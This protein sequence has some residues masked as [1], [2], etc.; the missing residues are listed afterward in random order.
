MTPP[1][2]EADSLRYLT[3][4]LI[5]TLAGRGILCA[6]GQ[7]GLGATGWLLAPAVAQAF[8][9]VALGMS[10]VLGAPIRTVSIPVWI[11]VL[12]LATG[13]IAF[14][15]M[16][17]R[18]R[19][20]GVARFLGGPPLALG[21]AVLVPGVG[22]LPYFVHGFGAYPGTTH[23]DAWSY[24]VFSAYLWEYPRL[25]EGGLSPAYQWAANL[26]GTRF[27][28]SASLGWL[29]AATHER[30]TQGAFGLLLVLSTFIIGSTCAAVGRGLGLPNKLLPLV[31]VGSGAGNWIAN[32][33][34]VSN[35]DNLL[36]LP[37]LPALAVLGIDKAATAPEGRA[38]VAGLLAAGTLYTYPEFALVVLCCGVLY[39][40]DWPLK[41]PSRQGL[42]SIL[43]CALT[44]AVLISPYVAELARFLQYQFS[45]G[46]SPN[47]RPGE[48][49]FS[50]LLDASRMPAALWALGAE[51][52]AKPSQWLANAAGGALSLLA[53]IGFGRLVRDRALG[54]SAT[55]AIL[56][57][58]FSVFVWRFDY[59]YGAYKFI[60]LGWW[61]A[62][63][64]VVLGVRECSR[65]H[66][67]VTAVAAVVATGTF[68]VALS[69][70]VD[71]AMTPVPSSMAAF[72]ELRAV[73]QLAHGAPIAIAVADNTAAHWATYFL[74]GSKTRLVSYSGYLAN[75]YFQPSM[76]RA[77]EIPW[78]SLR[79]LLTDATDGGPFVEQQYWKRLWSNSHYTLWD[80][81]DVGWAVVGQIDNGYPYAAG[82]DVVW[83][84]D[85]PVTLVATASAAGIATVHT[86]LALSQPLSPTV[87]PFRLLVADAAGVKCEWTLAARGA[88][89]L[90]GLQPG[91]NVVTL[92]KTSPIGVKV[93]P[94]ADQRH[95]FMVGLLKPTLEFTRGATDAR[96][97]H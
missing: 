68:S 83:V 16:N 52:S 28:A 91:K 70:S 5:W 75:P 77:T 72:R 4:A 31:A 13:G 24:T 50:G 44:A 71:A 18:V 41:L 76:A 2:A 30:D 12:A 92:A 35:L 21:V 53:V 40:L 84:G 89:L 90:L 22:L 20:M 17:K 59:S 73:E 60:L 37:Y 63:V 39:F 3:L 46:V 42:K 7:R 49:A 78:D 86:D 34:W 74:R 94:D 38:F 56:I 27:V 81:G 80:T 36:A 26:S 57:A 67:V 48:G 79:L 97:C 54:P 51:D 47:P 62:V 32:A 11:A 69:R 95:P 93:L 87:G 19:D 88:S 15:L 85:K 10:A 33:I 58:G 96:Y 9:A 82:P 25:T 1:F 45:S 64:G 43:F 66:P 14:D 65:I 61:L 55:L 8:V 6:A 29:S 23:P